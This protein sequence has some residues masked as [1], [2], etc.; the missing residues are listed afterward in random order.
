[1]RRNEYEP[2]VISPPGV[3]LLDLLDERGMS[4]ADLALRT[5]R[6]L[7]TINEIVKGKAAIAPDT[8]T[9]LERV[10][11]VPASFWNNRE[12]QYR[13]SVARRGH[14]RTR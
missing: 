8:A 7:K 12:V 2:D 9:Q 11:G 6:P 1:M 3:T 4:Q 5:G 10:F 13:K 14:E